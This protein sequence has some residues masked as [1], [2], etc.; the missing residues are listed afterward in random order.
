VL[1]TGHTG[2]KGSW[3]CVWLHSLG[4]DVAGYAHDPPTRPS[5]FEASGIHSLL[6]RDYREDI[7]DRDALRKALDETQPEVVLH[8]AARTVV[9][10]SYVDPV[11]TI[12]ANVMGTV[13]LL[14]AIRVRGQPC[15]VV[16]VS[17]DKC[18]ANDESGHP[19]AEDHPLGGDDPY[20][21]SK[22]AVELVT[23]A[24][25]HSFFP[26]DRLT[27]HGVA[28]ATARAGNVIG[29]GDW[30]ADGL[31]ADV[32]RHLSAG[33]E[34]PLRYPDAVRPWQHVLEPLAGYLTLA[35]ALLGSD[36]ARYCRAWNFGPDDASCETV[37][38][39]VERMVRAW[40]T[41]GWRTC[42]RPD[43]PPEAKLLR[44][45]SDSARR[46]LGWRGQWC[47]G[48]AVERTVAWYRRYESDAASARAACLAD[49]AAYTR[50][51]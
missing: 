47:I 18:Y 42:S 4:A 30:T 43:D 21:A 16:V 46:E 29:G 27:L 24:Y 28:L 37:A 12:S 20:S 36:A 3:L 6:A 40:G 1:V 41:G 51:P 35:S 39:V 22:G 38:Q 26:P 8:L 17:T 13:A 33:A 2:F 32:M 15:A 19:F 25:R 7:R 10:Q 34:V 49:I 50:A 14:E 23:Q 5:N 48:E 45:S 9:R 11:E 31:V 44:L